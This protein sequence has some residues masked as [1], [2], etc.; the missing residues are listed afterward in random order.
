MTDTTAKAKPESCHRKVIHRWHLDFTDDTTNVSTGAQPQRP[1]S[2]RATV[3]DFFHP[4]GFPTNISARDP[5]AFEAF[6]ATAPDAMESTGVN[7][8]SAASN[9]AKAHAVRLEAMRRAYRLSWKV[10]FSP[11]RTLFT[12]AFALYVAG[13]RVQVFSVTTTVTVLV[14]HI[15]TLFGIH[16]AFRPVFDLY[17]LPLSTVAVQILAHS[18]FCLIGV[19][20]GLY[21]ANLLGFLPTTESDW[22][23]LLPAHTI[24]PMA[25][26]NTPPL[27]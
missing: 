21:K 22:V 15:R 25:I 8:A 11:I 2:V 4:P 20:Q 5:A 23:A 1:A 6:G 19:C 10:A 12:S 9:D 14:M 18:V 16:D 3:E 7:S 27:Y 26:R 17:N 13:S 24:A